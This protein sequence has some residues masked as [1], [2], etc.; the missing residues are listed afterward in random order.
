MTIMYYFIICTELHF[1][2]FLKSGYLIVFEFY[3]IIIYST[4]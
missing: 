2:A 1:D 4:L 3:G